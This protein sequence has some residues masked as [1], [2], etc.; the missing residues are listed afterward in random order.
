MGRCRRLNVEGI[1]MLLH[2]LIKFLEAIF[3]IGMAGS[4]VVAIMAFV[5]DIHVFFDKDE[6][7][8]RTNLAS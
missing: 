1:Y 3:C 2:F 6:E 7:P 8:S 4:F 5:G